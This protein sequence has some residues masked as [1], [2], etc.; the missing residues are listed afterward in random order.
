[1]SS[2]L[3]AEPVDVATHHWPP[4]AV[5]PAMSD[6]PSPVKSATRTSSQVTAVDHE[7]QSSLTKPV[8][9][10][11]AIH[12]LPLPGSRPTMSSLPSPLKSPTC[13][14]A[15]LAA[16]DHQPHSVVLP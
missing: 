15:Q 11:F 13:T 12:Q 6:L 4:S 10:D 16:G 1:H 3:N 8:P 14:S 9:A 2:F 7:P 5:R